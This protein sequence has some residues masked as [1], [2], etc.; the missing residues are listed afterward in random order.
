MS[1]EKCENVTLRFFFLRGMVMMVNPKLMAHYGCV[2][3]R[4]ATKSFEDIPNATNKIKKRSETQVLS[5]Y[6]QV[7]EAN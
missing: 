2:I 3:S 1:S 5:Y 6:V 7:L 4:K